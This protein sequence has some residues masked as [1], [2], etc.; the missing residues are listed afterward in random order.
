MPDKEKMA[1]LLG[2]PLTS[3]E[4]SNFDLYLDIAVGR[5]SNLL[6][7]SFDT[8][9]GART[10]PSRDGYRTVYVDPFTATTSV[11][12]NGE[13]R[14]DY[15]KKQNDAYN[16]SWFNSI[17]FDEPL[18]GER[19]ELNATW[20]FGA[21]LPGDLA[22]LLAALF[23]VN[24]AEVSDVKSKKIEDFSVTYRDDTKLD[25]VADQ[26]KDTIVKYAVCQRAIRHGLVR[27]VY[28]L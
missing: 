14:T 17:E 5:L 6:C 20:G 24:E 9:G 1:E 3:A 2:R 21:T 18:C 16:G 13:A 12:V 10:F 19:V 23:A 7:F 8:A 27:P 11:T 25:Q 4:D 26:H 22:L 28:S 15:A